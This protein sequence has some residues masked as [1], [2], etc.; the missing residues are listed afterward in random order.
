[1][2]RAIR[3]WLQR[4]YLVWA[5]EDV[6]DEDDEQTEGTAPTSAAPPTSPA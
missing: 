3:E 5:P 1:M 4:N 2:E 6:E